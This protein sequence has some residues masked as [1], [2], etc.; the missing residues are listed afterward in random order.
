LVGIPP[1][2]ARPLYKLTEKDREFEWSKEAQEAFDGLKDKLCQAPLLAYPDVQK[3][4]ILDCDASNEGLGSVLSQI[5][6]NGKERPLAFFARAFSKTEKR[7]C[8]TRREL[9]A[10]V[11]SVK[12]FNHYLLGAKFLIRTDHNSIVWLCHFK[13]LDGQLARWLE[14]LVQYNCN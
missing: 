6:D 10:C 11:D 3:E 14:V 4:F 13:D 5:D 9:L 2:I 1:D 12:H 7:Y 8:V